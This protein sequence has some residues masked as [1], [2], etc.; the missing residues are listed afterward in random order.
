MRNK[1]CQCFSGSLEWNHSAR[2]YFRLTIERSFEIG[3]IDLQSGRG[4][5]RFFTAST[6]I[7]VAAWSKLADVARVNPAFGVSDRLPITAPVSRGDV[8]TTDQDLTVF[9]QLHFLSRDGFSDRSVTH[10]KRMRKT[11]ERSSLGHAIALNDCIAESTPESFRFAFER[12]AAGDER[13]ETPAKLPV[14]FSK[15]PPVSY[16]MPASGGVE[17]VVG[18]FSFHFLS[19]RFEH[20]RHGDDDVDA[21]LLY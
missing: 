16:E 20:A 13:P 4:D 7:N 21:M 19:Q 18:N 8:F 3:D 15:R 14:D 5:D 9:A 17:L 1:H 10:A 12:G 6:E 11:R 2:F